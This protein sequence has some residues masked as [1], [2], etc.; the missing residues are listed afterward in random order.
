MEQTDS[1]TIPVPRYPH[2][3]P[4]VQNVND[5]LAEQI[6]LEQRAADAFANLIG[7]WRFIIVQSVI[8]FIWIILN[9][10]AWINHWDPY[11]FILLNLALSFQA[12]YSGPIIMMSQNRQAEKDR[13]TAQLDYEVNVK[14]EDEIQALMCRIE[15]TEAYVLEILTLLKEQEKRLKRQ[16]QLLNGQEN[17]NSTQPG[18]R[19]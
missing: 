16:E 8:L 1:T 3:H 18:P 14:A 13:L 6:T 15:D 19:V 9:V 4:P 12:A 11:P 7:S 2:L 5:V 17:G 10:M